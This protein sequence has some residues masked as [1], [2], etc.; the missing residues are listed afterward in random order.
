MPQQKKNENPKNKILEV[1]R[2]HT[3]RTYNCI[4]MR[5]SQF[6]FKRFIDAKIDDGVSARKLIEQSSKPCYHCENTNVTF[7]NKDD[8]YVK[9]K[10]GFLYKRR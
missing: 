5:V 1:Y 7:I 4:I 8:E 6:E 2:G 9:V 3:V 10:R